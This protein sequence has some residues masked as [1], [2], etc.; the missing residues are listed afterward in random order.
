VEN[1]KRG[2]G[3]VIKTLVKKMLALLL[4]LGPIGTYASE[5]L[6]VDQRASMA[7]EAEEEEV[8]KT[9]PQSEKLV[10][11]AT[12]ALKEGDPNRALGYLSDESLKGDPLAALIEAEAHRQSAVEA[13]ARAGDYARSLKDKRA[14]LEDADLSAGLAEAEVRLNLFMD[15]LDGLYGRP[16]HLLQLGHEIK[17][18]FM[19]DK[20]RSRLFVYERDASG[21]F[22]RV[23]DEYVVTGAK[24][25]DKQKRGD[26]RTP[27]GIYRFVK[28]LDDEQLD[29]RY[30]PVAFPID[31]PNE[32]DRLH[33]KNG[34]GIWMHGY[35]Y[36]VD[37]RPPQDTRGCFAL[38]NDR[39]LAMAEHVHLKHSWVIVAERLEFDR[40]E[41]QK[42]LLTSVQGA[43]EK[44][45]G[46][47]SAVDTESY[48]NH[49]HRAFH[50]GKYDL[51]GWKRYKR[52]VNA[53]KSFID[54]TLSD[55]SLI[56]DPNIWPEGEVVV[57]EFNQY[58]RSNNFQDVSRKR[59]YFAR[60]NDDSDWK[61][62]I[63]ESIDR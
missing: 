36:G 16:M 57:A 22:K 19:V 5:D 31:Y 12:L 52:R 50:S 39:L 1:R 55:V 35:P 46:D 40:E 27:N 56:H 60:D 43:L 34:Y 30:G 59:I 11:R 42:G 47:W 21:E 2:I 7:L 33:N 29:D 23:A 17:S 3:F 54:L 63:E 15:R 32:L 20:A 49:Y 48:L 4:L 14:K 38:P 51:A 9:L 8:V 6:S 24:G 28:R 26:A 41:K 62:L 44:W 10:L 25:G 18:V 45:K 37:R 58:Y 61:I 53:N 13:V